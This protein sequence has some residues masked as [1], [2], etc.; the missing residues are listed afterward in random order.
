[1]VK[2]AI[3]CRMIQMSGI[4]TFLKNNLQNWLLLSEYQW[5]LLGDEKIIK[6]E[7]VIPSNCSIV[8]CQ[9]PIFSL[10]ELI[11][12]PIKEINQC[13]VY[14]SPNFNVPMGI[15]IP[16]FITVH[17]VVF[18]DFKDF[19]NKIGYWIR[20]FVLRRSLRLAQG[21]F[22]V[23]EFSK[24]RILH[25]FK[26][27]NNISV[28]YNGIQEDLLRFSAE[29]K[30]RIY[31]FEYMLFIGN[32]KRHKGLSV[33]L[34]A[35]E[36]LDKKLIIIGD[37]SGL[38]TADKI[39]FEK[40]SLNKNVILSGRVESDETLYTIISQADVLI[41][42]SRY[43]GFG[44]PPLEALYLNTPVILSN[45]EVFKEIY[46]EFPVTFFQ[47]GNSEDLKLKIIN[48]KNREIEKDAILE[49]YSYKNSAQILLTK[50]LKD[51]KKL[52]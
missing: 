4:G 36:K 46:G 21:V 34:S 13:D 41:Q 18:L 39:I 31:D 6:K 12:F 8:H 15:K 25:H 35:V 52:E 30:P 14:Y 44:L 48:R 22:T 42:P 23:S 26:K 7:L 40:L 29:N 5:V 24:K 37:V 51:I 10:K 38:K 20:Y 33:L 16:K 47:D 50:I 19:S 28:V 11:N 1:M 45:I 32:I 17:D 27:S 3:D 9:I 49:K 43:E 2:I